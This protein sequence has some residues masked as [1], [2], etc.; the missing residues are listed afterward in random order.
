MNF[1]NT[2]IQ[3]EFRRVNTAPQKLSLGIDKSMKSSN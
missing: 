2:S 3:D 1:Q